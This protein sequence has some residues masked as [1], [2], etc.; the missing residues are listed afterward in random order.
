MN[1]EDLIIVLETLAF[2]K[3]NCSTEKEALN[4]A[5]DRIKN[6]SINM[7]KRILNM[8]ES[9]NASVTD[10]QEFCTNY[11]QSKEGNNG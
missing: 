8:I 11:I 3:G 5:I 4:I 1:D 7:C 9:N 2:G 6:D 10:I